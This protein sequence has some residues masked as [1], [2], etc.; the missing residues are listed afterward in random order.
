MKKIAVILVACFLLFGGSAFAGLTKDNLMEKKVSKGM[1]IVQT[2]S[3]NNIS[4][5]GGE[6]YEKVLIAGGKN[7]MHAGYPILPYEIKVITF[8]FG[9]KIKDCLLYTSPSPRD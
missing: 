5:N 3:F 2:L 4:F 6:K 7:L 1:S 9:T 8:P